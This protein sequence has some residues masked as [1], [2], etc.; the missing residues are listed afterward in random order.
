[1][2]TVTKKHFQLFCSEFRRQVK[3]LGLQ[4]WRLDF[5]HEDCGPTTFSQVSWY[6]LDRIVRVSLTL[7][8]NYPSTDERIRA[9]ALHE[10]IE[11][12]VT[13]LFSL[14]GDRYV[15]EGELQ[16]TKHTLIRRLDK[17]L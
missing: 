9:A 15:N 2:P 12:L 17:V 3:R 4:E 13:D 16:A 10:A 14:A 11:L 1:M 5:F 6:Y 7:Q 8:T